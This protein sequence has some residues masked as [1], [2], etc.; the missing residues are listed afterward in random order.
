VDLTL[1]TVHGVDLTLF[2]M[3]AVLLS[4]HIVTYLLAMLSYH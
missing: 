4:L 2:P 1:F 3:L